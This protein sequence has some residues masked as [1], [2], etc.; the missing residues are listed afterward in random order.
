[1]TKQ[2]R[3]PESGRTEEQKPMTKIIA[4]SWKLKIWK[5]THAQDLME[6]ALMSG[7]LA[8]ASGFT[9]PAVAS[10]ISH[11]FRTVTSVVTS[12]IIACQHH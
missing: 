10:D 1:L 7:F 12:S 5:D 2:A 3:L 6:F 8:A 9:L 4:I 11:V